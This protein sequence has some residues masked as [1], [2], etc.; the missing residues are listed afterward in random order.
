[1]KMNCHFRSRWFGVDVLKRG[2]RFAALFA[3]G[4]A[5][6]PCSAQVTNRAARPDFSAFKGITERNIFNPNRSPKYTPEV[7]VQTRRPRRVDSVAL[8]GT[9]SYDE[10][11]PLAFF[12]GTASD[13]RK[14]L[15]TSDSIAGY[16]ITEIKPAGVK[17][18]AGTNEFELRI[19]MEL[20]REDQGKWR[21]AERAEPPSER[22]ERPPSTS[23]AS[24]PPRSQPGP[25][26]P[27]PPSEAQVTA[28]NPEFPPPFEPP[29]ELAPPD[30]APEPAPG[31]SDSDVLTRLME[32]RRQQ[33]DQ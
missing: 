32:R 16:R 11:G 7:R 10:R 17:L 23:T 3:L 26:A 2:C 8:V 12:D 4:L 20:R 15:K 6:L 21:M 28:V 25:A 29:P 24:S 5:A 1:M 14:V 31:G 18:A 9:M 13:Y 33:T 19:G 30:A 27:P 22:I